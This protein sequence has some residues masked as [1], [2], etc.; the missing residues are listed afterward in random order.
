VKKPMIVAAVLSILVA[1]SSAYAQTTDFFGLVKNGTPGEVQAAIRQGADV[2]DTDKD[3]WTPLM[4]AS[5][6]NQDPEV[7]AVLL[8]A[9]ADVNAQ[10]LV[11]MTP[12]MW[13]AWANPNPEVVISLL[14]AGADAKAVDLLGETAI[15]YAQTNR[16]LKGTEAFKELEKASK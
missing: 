3:G 9:G 6:Y 10:N 13:A 5:E 7:I 14:E 4:F 1:V 15:D 12:L 2:N 11:D 8:R 16:A